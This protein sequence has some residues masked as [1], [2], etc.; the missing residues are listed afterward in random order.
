MPSD[1]GKVK[2]KLREERRKESDIKRESLGHGTEAF[3]IS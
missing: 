2:R 3:G 1:R